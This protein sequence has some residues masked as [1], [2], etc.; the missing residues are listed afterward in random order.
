MICGVMIMTYKLYKK[1]FLLLPL[2][3]LIPSLS[4]ANLTPMTCPEQ[5]IPS[6]FLQKAQTVVTN[7]FIKIW[8]KSDPAPKV[9]CAPFKC[10]ESSQGFIVN[11]NCTAK[12]INKSG[13]PTPFTK[14]YYYFCIPAANDYCRSMQGTMPQ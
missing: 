10:Y 14:K 13:K 11:T 7:R 4:W 5:K 12:G 6:N 1:A 2:A 9:T 3:F 8:V